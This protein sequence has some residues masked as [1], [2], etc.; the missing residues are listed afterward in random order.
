MK[1]TPAIP[2]LDLLAA[3][4]D[5]TRLRLLRV[6]DAQELSVG[7]LA[8]ALQLPQSTVSRHL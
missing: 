3:L 2:L 7:E 5:P 4:S 1:T 8:K 6:L